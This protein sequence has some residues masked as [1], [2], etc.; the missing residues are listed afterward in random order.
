[1][2]ELF[3]C[4]CC[5]VTLRVGAGGK[6]VAHGDGDPRAAS[7]D[8]R[9]A[10]LLP[11]SS[12]DLPVLRLEP[13]TASSGDGL[14]AQAPGQPRAGPG[15]VPGADHAAEDARAAAPPPPASTE[16]AIAAL[17]LDRA[18]RE[19]AGPDDPFTLDSSTSE[20]AVP[21]RHASAGL[22]G[23]HPQ[24]NLSETAARQ[25]PGMAAP[26]RA[27]PTTWG[28]VLLAAYA[29]FLTLVLTW[30]Y[31]SGRIVD[32]KNGAVALDRGG[33]AAARAHLND[34]K[35]E[36]ADVPA[37]LT[38]DLGSPVRV[39][40]I[41]VTPIDVSS[42]RVS[43]RNVVDAEQRRRE[44]AE[45]L[46]LR[47]RVRNLSTKT[48]VTPIE[49]RFVRQPD[50]GIPETLIETGDDPI[51]PYPLALASEWEIIGQEFPELGPGE[52]QELL[53]VSEPGVDHRIRPR[54]TW[55]VRIR[56]AADQ[57]ELIAIEFGRHEL[58]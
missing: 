37:R 1:M 11:E 34:P 39:G 46:W 22:A 45:A 42:R 14:A 20:H 21:L 30:L 16:L 48:R 15:P 32:R 4:P 36:L 5:G 27:R 8:S 54:M 26:S 6:P 55:R 25:R 33:S 52:E 35:V 49:P 12:L 17:G 23:S 24:A 47:L 56:T 28:T 10:A 19:V 31:A 9:D 44:P 3:V 43:L 58:K 7:S 50:Q 38:T 57:T 40:E 2:S 51:Y 53:I 18:A 41:E 13:S 29:G